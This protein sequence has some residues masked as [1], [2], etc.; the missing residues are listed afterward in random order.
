MTNY[1]RQG[2][3]YDTSSKIQASKF[4]DNRMDGS[5]YYSNNPYLTGIFQKQ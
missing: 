4:V 1:D 5:K 3:Y 2:T